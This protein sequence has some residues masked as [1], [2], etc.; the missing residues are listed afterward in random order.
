[1]PSATPRRSRRPGPIARLREWLWRG[2]TLQRSRTIGEIERGERQSVL[3]LLS[4]RGEAAETLWNTGHAAEALR[5]AV[6]AFHVGEAL[7]QTAAALAALGATPADERDLQAAR[8]RL[9]EGPP[10][11]RD[12][13]TLDIGADY[14][15]DVRAGR[16]A[17]ERLYGGVL[18]PPGELLRQRALR[19]LV[20]SSALAA[21]V[22]VVAYTAFRPPPP[23]GVASASY[24]GPKYVPTHA[25]DNDPETEWLL[26]NG[27]R[28]WVECV[29]PSPTNVNVVHV[30]NGRN[31]AY[32]DRAVKDYTVQLLAGDE[33]V[34]EAE[35]SFAAIEPQ[36]E[37]VSVSVRGE[38][39]TKVRLEVRSFHRLGAALAELDWR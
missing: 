24:E 31:Q 1:M 20:V 16:Q 6:D 18:R 10:P 36:P 3:A 35:G 13:D 11:V 22:A 15:V 14:Y 2:G 21:V 8:R 5:L 25:C 12:T 26:P 7:P 29:L 27:S 34:A 30:T 32:G 23:R 9:D 19:A 33:V 39:I 4:Q 28:G 38:G 17:L 37:P